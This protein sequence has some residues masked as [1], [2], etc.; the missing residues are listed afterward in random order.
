MGH[1]AGIMGERAESGLSIRKYC[2]R[3]GMHPNRYHYWQR[4]LRIAAA[5]ELQPKKE[6]VAQLPPGGWMQI[7]TAEEVSE[8]KKPENT[9][10]MIEIGKSRVMVNETTGTELLTKVCK[11]L[12]ELC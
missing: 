12:V 4:R 7:S 2:E 11:V 1:W 10:V 8:L 5:A 6:E 3:E 9:G